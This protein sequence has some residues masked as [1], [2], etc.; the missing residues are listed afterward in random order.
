MGHQALPKV[1]V[2]AG[3]TAHLAD[4]GEEQIGLLLRLCEPGQQL[5]RGFVAGHPATDL[6]IQRTGRFGLTREVEVSVDEFLTIRHALT[7]R[8]AGT[9]A[10]QM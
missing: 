4:R 9:H 8:A 6:G 1:R 3:R 10:V 5:E 2:V 7:V